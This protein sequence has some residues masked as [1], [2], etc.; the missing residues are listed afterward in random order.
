MYKMQKHLNVTIYNC[1]AEIR[2]EKVPGLWVCFN[3]AA[4]KPIKQS[5]ILV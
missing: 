5:I 4:S 3:N 1:A 2:M